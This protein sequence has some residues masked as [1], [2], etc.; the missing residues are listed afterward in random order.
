M[1]QMAHKSMLDFFLNDCFFF[2]FHLQNVLLAVGIRNSI[3]HVTPFRDAG[4]FW[5]NQLI[6]FFNVVDYIVPGYEL[7]EV[8]TQLHIHLASSLLA[9]DHCIVKPNSPL[10]LRLTIF[11]IFLFFALTER[12]ITH[13]A[14][15]VMLINLAHN[16]CDVS[17]SSVLYIIFLFT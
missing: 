11:Y 16:C 7:P 12:R 17:V 13:K 5:V 3:L 14:K 8:T 4:H 2:F 1:F 15:K 10:K 6:D 9:Y